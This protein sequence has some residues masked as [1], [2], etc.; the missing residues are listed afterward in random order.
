MKN[1]SL[2]FIFAVALGTPSVYAKTKV[3][4]S[5]KNYLPGTV[6]QIQRH[7]ADIS[8]NYVGD[9]RSDAPLRSDVYSYEVSIRVNCGTYVGR[10][11]SAFDYLPSIF[12]PNRTVQVRLQKHVMQV[13]V[14]GEKEFTMG[15]VEH[16]R[17]PT[18]TCDNH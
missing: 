1:S 9:N 10:Y 13:N 18:P 6:L 7:E 16:P 8:S 12:T 2:M 5:K 3:D 4:S 15:I 17:H 14:P 11:Q